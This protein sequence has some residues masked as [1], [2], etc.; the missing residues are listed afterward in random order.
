MAGDRK[1]SSLQSATD[2]KKEDLLLLVQ[3][4]STTPVSKKVDIA[5]F[6]GD[7]EANVA[8]SGFFSANNAEFTGNNVT[9]SYNASVS[10]VLTTNNLVVNSNT[11]QL[12]DQFT[13]ANSSIDD[14]TVS[15]GSIFYDSNYLYIKTSSN[16]IKRIALTS[17]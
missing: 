17:F 7:I 2:V 6:F 15:V 9:F 16:T 3:N 10:G 4:L 13:P 12:T 5:T 1:V 8:I 11:I 14:D